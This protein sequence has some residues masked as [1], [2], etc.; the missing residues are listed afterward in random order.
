MDTKKIQKSES[1]QTEMG[2]RDFIL[3]ESK[4]QSPERRW[5]NELLSIQYRIED[6]IRSEETKD[7]LSML[8][9]VKLYLS[10]FNITLK[11]MAGIFEMKDSNLHKYLKGDRRLN[12]DLAM[13]LGAFFHTRPELWYLIQAKN[14]IL[15]LKAREEGLKKY[16]KYDIEKIL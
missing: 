9:F 1:G 11:K 13:K 15:D 4:K 6:Y 14:E 3:S 7:Q 2:L 10:A 16:E 8:D 5:K 12:S